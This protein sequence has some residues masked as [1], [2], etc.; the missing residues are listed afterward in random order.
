MGEVLLKAT[1]SIAFVLPRKNFGRG[2][3]PQTTR[4]GTSLAV[5][6]AHPPGPSH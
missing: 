2:L 3:P 1:V 6:S 5:T 4:L